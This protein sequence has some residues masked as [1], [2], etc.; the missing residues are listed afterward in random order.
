MA[1]KLLSEAQVRR[2]AKLANL[3]PVNEMYDKRNDEEVM[4]E[5]VVQEEDAA[6]EMAVDAA[7]AGMDELPA[8]EEEELE[9]EAGDSDL[10]LSQDMVDA[11]AAALP[12]LQM[13]ADASGD[14][15][16]MEMDAEEEPEMEMAAEEEPEAEMED[17]VMEALDGVEYIPEQKEIVEEVA[18]RVAKRILKAKQAEKLMN[19]ALGKK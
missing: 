6:E 17:E 18:R 11:I 16:E 19:E 8:P 3:S 15:E 4:E 14:E 1:K 7:D 10:E 2:F 13:I 12:A 9:M 5:E